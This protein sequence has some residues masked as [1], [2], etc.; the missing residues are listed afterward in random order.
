MTFCVN[1]F[2]CI[3]SLFPADSKHDS[4]MRDNT[5]LAKKYR[6]D[7]GSKQ[8]KGEGVSGLLLLLVV[9]WSIRV[10]IRLGSCGEL[11]IRCF[12]MSLI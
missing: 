10:S 12:D 5:A 7:N 1:F 11:R 8:A 4:S 9:V 2:L 3:L 6:R